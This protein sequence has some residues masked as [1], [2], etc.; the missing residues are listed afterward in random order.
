MFVRITQ[1]LF[2]VFSSF[3]LNEKRLRPCDRHLKIP[4]SHVLIL[5]LL[6]VYS[7]LRTLSSC[8]CYSPSIVAI[9]SNTC[10]TLAASIGIDT[11][12]SSY[13]PTQA[14]IMFWSPCTFATVIQS[15]TVILTM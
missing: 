12:S 3:R 11:C 7:I 2:R 9:V 10:E 15:L 14:S 13:D 5:S 6:P 4:A 1:Q 8:V